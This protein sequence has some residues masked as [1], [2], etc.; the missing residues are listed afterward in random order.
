MD[1]NGRSSKGRLPGGDDG[2]VR[3]QGKVFARGGERLRLRGLTYGPFAPS[4]KGHPF[5]ARRR[6]DDDLDRMQAIGANSIRTYHVPPE[7]L[8]DLVDERGMSIFLDIP[9]PKHVCFLESHRAQADARQSVRRAAEIGRDHACVLAYGVG[10]EIPADIIRWHG[11]RRVERFLAE[12]QDVAR[13]ADP[14]CL[15]TYASYPPTEYLD[16]S[17]LDFVTFNVYL[18]ESAAFRDYVFRLQNLVGDRPLVLGEIGLDTLR[19]GEAEQARLLAGQL[20]EAA[21]MGLAGSY[22]FSWTDDWHT[23][24][25]PIEDW[26]FG[27]TDASRGPKVSYHAVRQVYQAPLAGLLKETP[28]VSVVVCTYNGGR[29]LDECVR[30][31]I[32][33]DYPDYEVIVVDDGSTDETGEV[34]ERY[35]EVRAIHQPHLG[36]SAA[37]NLG[38]KVATGSIIAYTDS[39]CVAVPDW[40]THLV[41]QL[42]SSGAAAV[43]GPNLTPEDGWLAACVAA[44]PGQPTHVLLGDQVAEHIPGCNM[45]FRR[46]ALEAINGFDTQ[47]RKAGDDVDICWRL[48]HEGLGI[49]FAPGA[50]VWHHR[51][52]NPRTFLRQQAGYG[53]A[54]GLLQIKH[55]D[56]F[57]GYGS[58]KWTGVM[59]GAS[60]MGLRIASPIIYRGIF[61][62]GMF[63]C[64]YQPGV[65]HW[66]ML[67]STLEW[68]VAALVIAIGGA[69]AWPFGWALGGG[70]LGL[71]MLVAVM[72]AAQARLAPGDRRRF[73]RLLIAA[74]C[75]AQPLVRS[76]ARYR[77]WFSWHRPPGSNP[78]LSPS[79]RQSLSWTGS[80]SAAYWTE[81]GKDRTEILAG[82]I[83][84]MDEH[85]WC[86]V[87]DT[88]WFD[89]DMAIYCDSGMVLKVATVQ[90]EH[91]QGRRLI[92]IRY[93]LR[94]SG[95]I[96]VLATIGVV[97]IAASAV[98][99]PGVAMAVAGVTGG[100]LVRAWAR[101]LAAASRVIALFHEQAHRLQMIY[102]ME[103]KGSSP[104][105]TIPA[106]EAATVD[107]PVDGSDPVFPESHIPT[108]LCGRG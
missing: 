86:K 103:D 15:V 81:A 14:E 29:T 11:A 60:V 83:G 53:E 20:R 78:A 92:R 68:Q 57:N 71:S 10:N 89:W 37:R 34:L 91:G 18:S 87:L 61:A 30:S 76:W 52:P 45:A 42:N 72:Q 106:E 3:V 64:L 97:V 47:F 32:A 77:T 90:E 12:L 101:G 21:L 79:S 8:L 104:A 27:I 100:F 94:P 49:T 67:P 50:F 82:A 69:L 44:A 75:Y 13:Q 46:E 43:G 4:A 108:F 105:S 96:K 62:T 85:R 28:R 16:L 26:A 88:G 35:P 98:S 70:M 93:R 74:L 63:Q 58:G 51:R 73:A 80:H 33:M 66:A 65:A 22:V 23:G 36:L 99:F 95:R 102:C 41:H 84:Y 17:F 38:L 48:Q 107:I 39:D 9:W 7:W 54:E 6:V 24:G 19:H 5:P 56:K 1:L 25:H 31:L 2:R 55:P 40:L 59:Y